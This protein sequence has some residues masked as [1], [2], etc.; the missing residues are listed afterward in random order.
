MTK[1]GNEGQ[2]FVG[3]IKYSTN[4]KKKETLRIYS[5]IG[6]KL[7]KKEVEENEEKS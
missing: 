5:I 4:S 7:E 3:A 1:F 2:R 6:V